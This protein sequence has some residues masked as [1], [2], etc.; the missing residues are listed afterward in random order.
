MKD[1]Y[2]MIEIWL[3]IVIITIFYLFNLLF[4]SIVF[5]TEDHSWF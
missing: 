5:I 3:V 2:K 4:M 1:F